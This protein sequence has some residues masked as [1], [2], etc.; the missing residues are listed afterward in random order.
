MVIFAYKANNGVTCSNRRGDALG[1]DIQSMAITGDKLYVVAA[2]AIYM[3]DVN[4][5]KTFELWQILKGCV[6]SK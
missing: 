5:T 1:Q 4:H 2:A 3:I 6:V